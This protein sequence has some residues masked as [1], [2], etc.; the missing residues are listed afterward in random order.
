[1]DF[2]TAH[3]VFRPSNLT[4]W[5]APRA[6]ESRNIN[7]A[8]PVLFQAAPEASDVQSQGNQNNRKSETAVPKETTPCHSIL[9]QTVADRALCHRWTL[10]LTLMV[11]NRI[12]TTKDKFKHEA[13]KFE[14]THLS[15]VSNE[16]QK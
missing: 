16:R 9:D 15:V 6:E 13:T 12:A 11:E 8:N 3:C 5:T 2:E 14:K 4:G 10:C 7:Q 1:M